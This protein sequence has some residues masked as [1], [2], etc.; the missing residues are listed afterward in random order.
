MSASKNETESLTIWW[1]KRDF[2]LYDN[3]AL[4]KAI[5]LGNN[6]LP[7]FVFEPDIMQA[8]DFSAMHLH[9]QISAA[10]DLRKRLQTIGSEI[11]FI[12]GEITQAFTS[13]LEKYAIQTV[14]SHEETGNDISF[15]RD[16][17]LATYLKNNRISWQELPQNG[18]IRRLKTRDDRQP[19]IKKRLFNKPPIPAPEEIPQSVMLRKL[20]SQTMLPNIFHFYSSDNT[21]LIKFD[22]LQT[23]G[24]SAAWQCLQ[25][26]LSIRGKGYSGGISSPNTAFKHGS[27][28]SPHIAWGTISLRAL[29]SETEKCYKELDNNALSKPQIIQ[30]R[31]SLRA[32]QSRLHWHCHFIQRLESD[33]Y[34]EF[35]PLNSAYRVIQYEDSNELLTAWCAGKTGFPLVDA[36][37]RCL[38]AIG[39]LNFRM[40]AFVVSFAIFGLHLDWRTIH[41]YLARIFYDYEPGIHLAQLQMQAGIVGINTI[42]VYNPTK[43]LIDQDSNCQFVKQ[44]V[45]ELSSFS[46]SDIQSYESLPLDHYPKPIIDFSQRSKAMKDQIFNI[47][48]SQAGR[49]HSRQVL[50]NHG[51]RKSVGK[52]L[53]SKK[54]IHPQLDLFKV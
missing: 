52:K 22:Q 16:K 24:E 20:A 26:F 29:F 17:R 13:L 19:I 28:L 8:N 36:C 49:M 38:N 33:P 4:T 2:R 5:A 43:Q 54:Q 25:S 47:R 32:F 42:R 40:R 15:K 23:I 37:M 48:K 6:V 34:M 45:P 39:F 21:E 35:Q 46:A 50:K 44:W 12:H 7:L 9:A 27:R 3:E 53:K 10:K 30:W 14:V 31:R 51:S 18:V 11:M 41:P 1:I